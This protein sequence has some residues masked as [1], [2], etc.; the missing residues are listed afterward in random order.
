MHT[1]K[2]KQWK[3]RDYGVNRMDLQS[4]KEETPADDAVMS[5]PDQ[6]R[7]GVV[8]FDGQPH[9]LEDLKR[10]ANADAWV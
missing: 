8:W 6:E 10:E 1:Q 5:G 4:H 7:T 3:A 9:S 2:Q